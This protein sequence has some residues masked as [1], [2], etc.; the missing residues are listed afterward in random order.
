[1][2]NKRIT[3]KNGSKITIP[4]KESKDKLRGIDSMTTRQ[5]A[6]M[7]GRCYGKRSAFYMRELI[8]RMAKVNKTDE[9]PN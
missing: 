7:A 8:K 9:N 5:I 4:S 1:M 6:F 2:S 3:F